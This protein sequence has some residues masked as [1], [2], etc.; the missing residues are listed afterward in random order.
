[1]SCQV[2]IGSRTILSNVDIADDLSIPAGFL[3]HTVA[4]KMEEDQRRFVTVAFSVEDDMKLSVNITSARNLQFGGKL[5]ETLFQIA[6]EALNTKSVF[7]DK[8]S[9]SLW[10]ARIFTAH[11]SMSESFRQTVKLVSCL[12]SQVRVFAPRQ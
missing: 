3:Y 4:I 6:P 2:C 5:M 9:L 8:G 1:M 7:G 12:Q 10:N 11:S